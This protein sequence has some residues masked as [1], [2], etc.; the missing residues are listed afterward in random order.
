MVS[1]DRPTKLKKH[2][3]PHH[4]GEK[5]KKH[6]NC[7]GMVTHSKMVLWAWT[8]NR[9]H[10]R[11]LS[12]GYKANEIGRFDFAFLEE[13]TLVAGNFVFLQ[14]A[15]TNEACRVIPQAGQRLR[16]PSHARRIHKV[17]GNTSCL[18]RKRCMI[19]SIFPKLFE[20]RCHQVIVNSSK[21]DSGARTP[22]RC[23]SQGT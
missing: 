13:L 12:H 9:S 15:G 2:G 3:V 16:S 21:W 14:P 1:R 18:K 22:E 4:P 5:V 23:T 17:Y 7:V 11:C 20:G 6:R 10:Y 19:L 8:A